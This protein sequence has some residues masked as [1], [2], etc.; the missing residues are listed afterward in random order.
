MFVFESTASLCGVT[1]SID[2]ALHPS[3]DVRRVGTKVGHNQPA[4][5]DIALLPR[6]RETRVS[7]EEADA[8]RCIAGCRPTGTERMSFTDSGAQ[9]QIKKCMNSGLAISQGVTRAQRSFN[10][11]SFHTYRFGHI[12]AEG[13]SEMTSRQFVS[14]EQ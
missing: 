3:G 11:Y 7:R 13:G 6:T 4:T 14:E 2:T 12:S 1:K 10:R 9:I 5:F 8:V